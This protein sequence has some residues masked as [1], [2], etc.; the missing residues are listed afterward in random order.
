MARKRTREAE[1]FRLDPEARMCPKF[2]AV[3]VAKFPVAPREKMG[4]RVE[5]NCAEEHIM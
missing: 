2:D 1:D 3:S 4:V 5:D